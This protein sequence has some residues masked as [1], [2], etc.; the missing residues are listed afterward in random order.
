MLGRFTEQLTHGDRSAPLELYVCHQGIEDKPPGAPSDNSVAAGGEALHDRVPEQQQ[1]RQVF[2]GLGTFG[3][4][5]KIK[6]KEDATP[7]SLYAPRNVPIFLLPKNWSAC[8]GWEKYERYLN[9]HC[10][11]LKPLNESVLREVYPIPTVEPSW[12]EQKISVN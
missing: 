6:L 11:D 2:T 3:E 4:E 7:F 8:K 5:Y 10:V 12:Q 1:F 9:L